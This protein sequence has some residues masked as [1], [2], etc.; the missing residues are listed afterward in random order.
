MGKWDKCFTCVIMWNISKKLPG[1][2]SIRRQIVKMLNLLTKFK[3]K[4]KMLL[5]KWR[6]S[7]IFWLL[8]YSVRLSLLVHC[9]SDAKKNNILLKN[10]L[11]YCVDGMI[12]IYWSRY[13]ILWE[14]LRLQHFY[15]KSWVVS[16]YWFK[17]E[18]STEII[19]LT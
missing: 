13:I 18:F 5:H 14:V 7:Q 12:V 11:F 9:S 2:L 1:E 10:I 6:E 3:K 17:F 19:F 15:N 4:K 8:S 16:Y